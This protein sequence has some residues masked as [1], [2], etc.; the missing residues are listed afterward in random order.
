MSSFDLQRFAGE[1]TEEPTAKRKGEARQKGQVPKSMDFSSAVIMLAAFFSLQ[2]IAPYMYKEISGLMRSVFTQFPTADFTIASFQ[3]MFMDYGVVFLKASLPIMLVILV[4][5]LVINY[6]QVGFLFTLQPLTPS[7]SK[8]NPI[9]GLERMFSMQSM[10][11]LIKSIIKISVVSFFIYRFAQ[12]QVSQVAQLMHADLMD[13]MQV[14]GS[15]TL[16]LAFQI[17]TVLLVLSILDYYFQWWQTNKNMKMDKQEVKEEMKQ[18][19]GNP[20][21]KSKIKERQRAL[22][23]KRMMQ[24]VPKADVIITN[25][26]HFAVALKYDADMAAPI[27]VAKGQDYIAQKIKAIAK[28]HAIVIVE[29]RMLARTLYSSVEIGEIIPA[30]LYQA[31]AEVLAY[32]YRL[33]KRLS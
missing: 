27:V 16:K 22:A 18:S 19:E 5:G 15:M 32:V 25:P 28:E 30:E 24:E 26:T 20:Q 33:K 2:F 13:V 12:N 9:S 8:L 3:I 7:L 29:N 6:L 4:V 1:K 14:V 11:E 31:V 10:V 21:I 23:L 17:I